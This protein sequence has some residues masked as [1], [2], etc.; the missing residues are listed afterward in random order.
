MAPVTIYSF[1]ISASE[2]Q[3]MTPVKQKADPTR[4]PAAPVKRQPPAKRS[5]SRK[6][7]TARRQLRMQPFEVDA[8]GA[9][10]AVRGG[11]GGIWLIYVSPLESSV[12]R[13]DRGNVVAWPLPKGAGVAERVWDVPSFDASGERGGVVT[14]Y[15]SCTTVALSDGTPRVFVKVGRTPDGGGVT[16]SR[17]LRARTEARLA[18]VEASQNAPSTL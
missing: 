9:V 5:R 6:P 11:G 8:R 17:E 3:P 16:M 2:S 7:T 10:A 1:V 13:D 15:P 4:V 14:Y 12:E 18:R